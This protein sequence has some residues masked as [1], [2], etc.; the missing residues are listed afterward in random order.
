[1]CY[2]TF[3]FIR[4]DEMVSSIRYDTI[5]LIRVDEMRSSI[6]Y[7][8]IWLMRVDDMSSHANKNNVMCVMCQTSTNEEKNY[9]RKKI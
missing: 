3:C 1:M 7:E 5:W 2:E 9:V 8:T 4:V 6:R